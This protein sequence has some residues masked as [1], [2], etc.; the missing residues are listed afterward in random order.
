MATR[1]TT[2]FGLGSV[3]TWLGVGDPSKD[4]QIEQIADAVSALIERKTHRTFVTRTLTNEL[5][6]GSGHAVLRV[7]QW[8][9]VTVTTLTIKRT[10]DGTAEEIASTDYDVDK[11]G[12]RI[13]LRSSVLPFTALFQNVDLTYDAGEGTQDSADLDAT[14]WQLGLDMV[15]VIWSKYTSGAI[16]ATSININAGSV[17]MMEDWPK[18]IRDGL[19]S[20]R[21]PMVG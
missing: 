7:R 21:R 12:G 15:K 11:P 9:I 8:P 5:Y 3:K 1:A 18:H 2:L 13:R 19:R 14:A 4:T 10:E 17:V 6:D 20:L 16:M